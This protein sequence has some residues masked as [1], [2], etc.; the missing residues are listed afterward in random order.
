MSPSS[1][2]GPAQV[3]VAQRAWPG[4]SVSTPSRNSSSTARNRATVVTTGRHRRPARGTSCCPARAEPVDDQVGLL[5]HAHPRG[6]QVGQRQ[7]GHRLGLEG[8]RG[9]QGEV[10]R[11]DRHDHLGQQLGEPRLERHRPRMAALPPRP[12]ASEISA[13]TCLNARYCMS[14]ANSRS[15]A[16]SS[17]RS[18]SSSTSPCGSSRAVLRSSSVDATSRNWVVCS[19]SSPKR[20]DVADELVGDLRQRHFGDVELVLGDQRQQQVERA[21]E[22]AEA[23]REAGRRGAARRRPRRRRC[24]WRAAA[25]AS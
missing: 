8:R 19:R 4:R 1:V 9:E 17:A 11:P 20:L 24:P 10:G 15:R 2:S 16:S 7:H 3:Q 5:A 18:S 22:H 13:A 14:R 6:V 12:A 23:D 21:L 25:R